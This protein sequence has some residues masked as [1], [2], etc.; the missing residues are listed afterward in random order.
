MNLTLVDVGLKC[1]TNGAGVISCLDPEI[2]A[3]LEARAYRN[4]RLINSVSLN[5][6]VAR[7]HAHGVFLRLAFSVLNLYLPLLGVSK[8]LFP[9]KRECVVVVTIVRITLPK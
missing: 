5:D 9:V 2:T 1:H 8:L 3:I 6:T 7:F 4:T